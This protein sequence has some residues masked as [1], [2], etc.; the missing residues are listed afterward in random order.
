MTITLFMRIND[1][2]VTSSLV[3][4]MFR[5]LNLCEKTIKGRFYGIHD[6]QEIAKFIDENLASFNILMEN[7][8]K[9]ISTRHIR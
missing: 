5:S 8:I 4:L 9:F 6:F 1:H 7:I 2:W 3:E